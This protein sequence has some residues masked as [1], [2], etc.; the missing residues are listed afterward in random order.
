MHRIFHSIGH[1]VWM[2]L[3]L[4]A[5][6]LLLAA[7][8]AGLVPPTKLQLPALLAI[9]FEVLALVNA[10]F[11]VSWLF[12][13]HKSWCVV[14]V[15][16]LLISF[17]PLRATFSHRMRASSV[18]ETAAS[19]RLKILS[20]NTHLLQ[21]NT[22][23]EKNELLR[24]IHN[25]DAD[26]VCLQ[27]YAVY[28]DAQYPTF[29]QVKDYLT[30]VFPYTYFDFSVHNQRLQYGLAV[31]SKY[32]LL[33]KTTIPIRASGN[34]ANYCDI[35]V[36]NDTFRLF[37]NHLQSNS[38]QTSEIDSLLTLSDQRKH[39]TSLNTKLSAKLVQRA[40]QVQIIRGEI[41]R[42]P[43][44]VIVCGDFNDVPAS[45]TYRHLSKGLNDAFLSAS[46]LRTG[47]TFVMRCLGVRID[48]I[49]HSDKLNAIDFCVNRVPYSDHYPV[50]ATLTWE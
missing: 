42:S 19:S 10:V 29:Q 49:L 8:L 13:S 27:E 39:L 24:Y 36:R 37:N 44:P 32:P 28:K 2:T 50:S 11:A 48:Y 20:Y 31:Y 41:D 12:S 3:N 4:L 18:S 1:G 33:N 16:A 5:V 38:L 26:V 40:E 17:T 47:H 35:V 6:T 21:E 45:Y 34:G 43:H 25:S 46:F 7:D 14:S 30:E 15:L 22:P 23:F 9:G